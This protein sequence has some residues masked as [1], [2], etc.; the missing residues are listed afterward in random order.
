MKLAFAPI[1]AEREP[2]EEPRRKGVAAP[3]GVDDLGLERRHRLEAVA[4]GDHRPVGAPRGGHATDAAFQKRPAAALEVPGSGQPE[5]LLL[6]G[7]QVIEVL[8][9]GS[10]PVDDRG[11]LLAGRE[12]V[13]GRHRAVLAGERQDPRSLVA[14]H[15]L[16]RTEMQVVG[17]L[18]RIPGRVRRGVCAVRADHVERRPRAV[19]PDRQHA[20]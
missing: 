19:G 18:D 10:Q 4:V 12:D 8:E 11:R 17:A 5:H 3:G 9:R 1:A 20:R 13:R 15:E 2:A 16:G 6:V 14:A 7:Q